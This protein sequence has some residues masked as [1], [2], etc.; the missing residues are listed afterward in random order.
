MYMGLVCTELS[1]GQTNCLTETFFDQ[2]EARARYL[3]DVKAKGGHVGPLHGLPISIKD[4]FQVTGIPATL[5]LVAYL[6][7]RSEKNSPLVDILESMGA[8]L[9]VKTNVPQTMMVGWPIAWYIQ[10]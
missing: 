4:T 1:H 7:H 8:I 6:K 2:A 5:G 10:S 3:D 9:Y